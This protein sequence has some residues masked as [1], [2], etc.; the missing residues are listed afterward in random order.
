MRTY[1][2]PEQEKGAPEECRKGGTSG[3][4]GQGGT[5]GTPRGADKAVGAKI[6]AQEA[7]PKWP[8]AQAPKNKCRRPKPDFFNFSKTQPPFANKILG[9]S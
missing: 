7:I 1:G 3:V 9:R 8:G 5:G 6:S 2:V 4:W